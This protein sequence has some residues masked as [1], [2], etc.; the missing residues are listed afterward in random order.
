M[1]ENEEWHLYKADNF[2]FNT[3]YYYPGVDDNGSYI[4]IDNDKIYSGTE[5]KFKNS[6]PFA[7]L[8]ENGEKGILVLGEKIFGKKSEKIFSVKE[9][10]EIDPKILDKCI[11]GLKQT[12][13]IYRDK[14]INKNYPKNHNGYPTYERMKRNGC[15]P[16]WYKQDGNNLYLSFACRG[17]VAFNTTIQDML[18][19]LK[20]CEKTDD[21]CKA[22]TLFGMMGT[23]SKSSMI[24]FTD[25]VCISEKPNVGYYTLQELSSP[26]NSYV[27]FYAD[28]DKYD[29]RN[30]VNYDDGLKIRGRKFYWHS[31]DF[32]SHICKEGNGKIAATPR[33]TTINLIDLGKQFTFNI[34]FDKI[35]KEQLDELIWSLNFGENNKD[36]ILCHKLCHGKP[37]G[38]GSAKI[39]VE[40]IRIRSYNDGI[41][42]IKPYPYTN[43]CEPKFVKKNV[44][45][46]NDLKE[47]CTFK[48]REMCYPFITN[49]KGFSV[50][51]NDKAAH[52]WF[53]E[54]KNGGMNGKLGIGGRDWD[55]QLL[56]SIKDVEN[57]NNKLHAFEIN[58]VTRNNNGYYK[59]KPNYKGKKQNNHKKY[60]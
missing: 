26:K 22:C 52:K 1:L 3:E 4:I 5:V 48:D 54:N 13:E 14:A 10:L 24:R 9:D 42:A 53:Y 33:N 43:I 35:S 34:Y 23:Q 31:N 55:V 32:M 16:V 2:R 41:Y 56:P 49:P 19:Q 17:R 6:K 21:L 29:A 28:I 44:C 15:I 18:D 27:P 50:K 57:N 30:P 47:I 46:I 60:Y 7:E 40:S 38:L 45:T 36:S 8:S 58:S 11:R 59:G 25:A 12:V 39:T 20:S 37:L 51:D